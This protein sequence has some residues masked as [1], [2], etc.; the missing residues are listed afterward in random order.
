MVYIYKKKVGDKEYYYLRASLKKGKKL[1]TKDIAYL[2]NSA[3]EAKNNFEKVKGYKNEIRKSYRKISLFL[4]ANHYLDLVKKQ[5]LKTDS[6]LLEK[7]S[8]VEACKLHYEKVFQKLDG[9]TKKQMMDNFI[10]DFVYNTTSIEGNT[11][12]LQQVHNLFEEGITPKGKTLREV[13]DLQNTKKVFESLNL[14]D[15]LNDKLV[16]KIHE[17]LMENVDARIGYRTKDVRVKNSHFESTPWQYILADMKELF[18][19][20]N[21]EKNKFHP[22]VLATIFHH[23]F[24]KI[25]PFFDGNGRTGR[26]LANFILMKNKYPPII[27]RKKYR[28]QYLDSLSEADKKNLFS[29]EYKHY[30]TIVQFC[31]TEFTENYWNNFL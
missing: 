24:E 29:K 15:K 12:E 6:L 4:E 7:F 1:V 19:W 22:L 9:L 2:G 3:K 10:I 20:Y 8:E 14:K 11:I 13:F 18:K 21:L 27:I 30:K 5:K 28:T 23:R 26:I 16:I 31:A 17:G 25:H